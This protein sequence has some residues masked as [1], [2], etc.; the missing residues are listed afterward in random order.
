MT[1]W[2]SSAI[3]SIEVPPLRLHMSIVHQA[4]FVVVQISEEDRT[5]HDSHPISDTFLK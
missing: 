2:K 3:I 4:F 5:A 1:E